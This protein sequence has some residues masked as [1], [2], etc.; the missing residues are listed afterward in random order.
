MMSGRGIEPIPVPAPTLKPQE[1][2]VPYTPLVYQGAAPPALAPSTG[3]LLFLN[4]T[5]FS[6]LFAVSQP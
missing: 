1:K 6:R 2:V 4:T 3:T 5:H